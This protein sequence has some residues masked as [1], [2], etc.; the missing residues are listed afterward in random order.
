MGIILILQMIMV[1]SQKC[2]KRNINRFTSRNQIGNDGGQ[3][4]IVMVWLL[5]QVTITSDSCSTETYVLFLFINKNSNNNNNI[6]RINGT[7]YSML[8]E[9]PFVGS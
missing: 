5:S 3:H 7:S 2:H 8:F 9:I 4:V 1:S 6:S